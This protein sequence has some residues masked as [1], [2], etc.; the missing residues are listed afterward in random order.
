MRMDPLKFFN[1]G[2]K[3]STRKFIVN[4]KINIYI[5]AV[6][7]VVRLVIVTAHPAY[8]FDVISKLILRMGDGFPYIHTC[9]VL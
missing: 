9:S 4:C 6:T 2:I 7:T 5:L 1:V 8:S 3:P